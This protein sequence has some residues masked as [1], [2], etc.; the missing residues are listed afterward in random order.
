MVPPEMQ[1]LTVI[2]WLIVLKFC[3]MTV[4]PYLKPAVGTLAYGLA[5]PFSVLVLT[6]ISWYLGFAGIPVQLVLVPFAVAG[7]CAVW[8]KLYD[9]SE[10]RQSLRWDLVFFGAFA[11]ML[12]SR[13]YTPGIVPSGEKFMDAAFLGSIMLNPTV[14]PIDPWYAGGDLSIYYYLGHW[15][16]G[17][18]GVLTGG[19]PTVV[20]NL[21][22]PTV[23][24]LAAVSAYAIGVLI[25]KRHQ[26]I[27]MLV[28][29]L[30][31]AAL[32]WHLFTGGGAVGIWWASTRVIENTIN[33]YPLFSFLWGDPH[34]HLL[35]S[36]NQLF[37]LALL[38]MMLVKWKVL[39]KTGRYL[40]AVML[41]LSLGTMPAM[42]SWD[43]MVYAVVY[44]VVALLLWLH[45]GHK[46]EDILPL[47]L[48]PVLS[49]AS[50]APFLYTMLSVGGS[51]VLGF[52]P[53]TT[54]TNLIEFFGV[55]L[56][57]IVV[58][59]VY[60]FSVLKKYPWLV[61]VPV[62][63][64]LAGYAV[65]GVA[66]FCILLLAGKRSL[67]PE[68]VFGILGM[69]IVFLME[70]V[71]LK[72]YMGDAYYRMNTVFKFGFCA[73]FMLGSSMLLIIGRWAQDRWEEIS[74][75]RRLAIAVVIFVVLA[76]LFGFCGIHLGY[77]GGNLDGA[78]WLESH[79]PA[80]AAGITFITGAAQPGDMVVEAADGSYGYNGRVSAM[81]GLP[82]IVGWVGHEIGWRSGTGDAN[83]R[84]NEV[85]LIYE[86]SSGTLEL[87]DKY[88]AEYLFV[89]DVEQKLYTVNL[90]DEGLTQVFAADGVSIYQRNN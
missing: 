88:G 56:F 32:I 29:I 38:A 76:A 71:Y 16:C 75:A 51:S 13:I 50:Y 12:I 72:D 36:F 70:F 40:L 43:V 8:K 55:Y 23:F 78:A 62:V 90:P 80:D 77:P 10:I 5:Y 57:F 59:V 15:M 87:M 73:W 65:A 6:L 22:L 4:Y 20:F 53:V 82:T 48:V 30:P 45:E 66:L 67:L 34:A 39:T 64:A 69:A 46:K 24:A 44:L 28:L 25:L 9:L 41:A 49:L 68:T 35:G 42:N 14:T 11:L 33:E 27:P 89:G 26:W 83:T 61:A 52:F 60:G 17:M 79:Y 19:V 58:F 2:L 18:L 63:F 84:G 37:F 81:T 85:R 74:G 47:A 86:D 7:V 31:N 1:I 21:M 3:Q 54:P